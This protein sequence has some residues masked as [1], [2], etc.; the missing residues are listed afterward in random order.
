[1]NTPLLENPPTIPTL[2]LQDLKKTFANK[3]EGVFEPTHSRAKLAKTFDLFTEIQ[4]HNWCHSHTPNTC[5]KDQTY[6]TP[7]ALTCLILHYYPYQDTLRARGIKYADESTFT[8]ESKTFQI[9]CKCFKET[10]EFHNLRPSDRLC[11]LVEKGRPEI[12]LA[13]LQYRY[14]RR[15]QNACMI[16]IFLLALFCVSFYAGYEA[17]IDNK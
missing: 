1:M 6:S 11:H 9:L 7:A 5:S 12:D 3:V 10:L 8:N 4:T 13:L 16:V 17:F 15:R 2:S 14:K